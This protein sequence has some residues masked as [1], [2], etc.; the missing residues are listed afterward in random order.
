V[1]THALS[2]TL[3]VAS[4]LLAAPALAEQF[5]PLEVLG[6]L[7]NEYSLCDNC[8][9]GLVNRA[10]YDP[11]GVLM[12]PDPMVNQGGDSEE[13][14][15]NLFLMQLSLGL[16]YEFDNAVKLEGKAAGRMR[17]SDADIYD[18]WLIDLYAGASHPR[19]GSLQV[20]K[21]TSRSWSRS[22]SF[23]YPLGLSS[24]WA[25]SGAGYGV[26]P[27]AVRYATPEYEIRFGKI[28]FEGSYAR[29]DKRKP[30]NPASL[31]EGP[32]DPELYEIFVQ[33]SNE[34]NLIELIYQD[35][36]G[37]RQS[38]F[39]K[40]AFYGAQGNTNG[41]VSSPEYEAPWE[42]VLILQG[43]HW[44]N[45]TW[46]FSYGLKRSEWSGQAQQ[47]DFGP[48]S[49]VESQ[50]FWDQAGF[51]YSDDIDAVY[52]AVSYDL[53]LGAAYKRGNWTYT[54]G[55]VYLNESSTDNPVEWGQDNSATFL[56]LGVYRKMPE[57]YRNVE[58]YAGLGRVMFGRQGPAP[59]SMPSN[60]AF[61]GVDPRVSESGNFLTL[62]A[63]FNF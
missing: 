41:L 26:F 2:R 11:R 22:D 61:G 45:A 38:S 36:D 47:C 6:F 7:K 44:F 52:D 25:E 21:M 63:N 32:P 23:A 8:S 54:L 31:V 57:I 19:F 9:S 40:G 37:G 58:F 51:N 3:A 56:N 17:N 14:G 42:N 60:V 12:P 1:N 50:C 33:F 20:G 29:A 5:G 15:R 10:S 35:S 13:T 27:E 16:A 48:V 24:P 46:S 55:G 30:L 34:K 53:M 43:T 49:T 18:N 59:V 62:G 28:R 4:T 39:S